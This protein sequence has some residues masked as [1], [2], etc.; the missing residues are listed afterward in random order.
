MPGIKL[1][2]LVYFP[3]QY[4]FYSRCNIYNYVLLIQDTIHRL[5][6]EPRLDAY[7]VFHEFAPCVPMVLIVFVQ[8]CGCHQPVHRLIAQSLIAI[9]ATC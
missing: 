7:E 6:G 4:Q 9:A 8:N 1:L 2:Y 3:L 5:S